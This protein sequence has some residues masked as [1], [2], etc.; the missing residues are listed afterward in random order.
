MTAEV[1]PAVRAPGSSTLGDRLFGAARRPVD[2]ASLAAFRILFG[3]TMLLGVVRFLAYGWVDRFFVQPAFHFTYWGFDWVKPWPSWGMHAHFVALAVLAAM[4]MVGLWYR[5]AI[6]LF[7]LGFTYVEL[8]DV[9]YYLNHY[10]LVTLLAFLLCFLPANVLWSMDACLQPAKRRE[11]VPAIAV[12]ILRLQVGVVYFYA[13]LAKS[14][15]DWLL[16]AQPL[17]IWLSSR[18]DFPVVGA[19]FRE[20]ATAYAMSWAGFLYDTTI[21][22]WLSWRRTRLPAYL[23]L[24]GF[25]TATSALFRIGMFPVIMSGAALIF[26]SPSWP[27]RLLVASPGRHHR[28]QWGYRPK[29]PRASRA[30]GAACHVLQP[31]QG[32]LALAALCAYAAVQILMPL[33]HR[34]YGGDVLWH[35]Q[36]MRWAWKVMVR[37]K[38][39]A[40]TY[41]VHV[42]SQN[43]TFYVNP[44]RYLDSL[45]VREMSGQPDL[46]LKLAHHVRDDFE[47]RGHGDVQVFAKATVSLN[48]RRSVAMIDPAIDLGRVED[49]VAR[50]SWILPAPESDPPLLSPG[51]IDADAALALGYTVH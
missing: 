37:E 44:A 33:R 24:L 50:A 4:V 22:L 39:G 30:P 38:N 29:L 10:Y 31:T 9:T 19:L 1:T 6:V 23:V 3:A 26:F 46:I 49:G 27:R 15:P 11:R 7:F 12:W 32:R 48:G 16:G 51:R 21:V 36:G 17:N 40:I 35:E 45:Q 2:A 5:T 43:K 28:F 13:G 14:G 34:L 8:I 25:H 18:T 42:P 41:L 47:S 20:P